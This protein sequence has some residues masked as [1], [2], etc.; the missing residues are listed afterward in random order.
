V[1]LSQQE[2]E[3]LRSRLNS[4]YV[5][6]LLAL[7]H[8]RCPIH[9]EY[10]ASMTRDGEMTFYCGCPFKA[11]SAGNKTGKGNL[12]VI[13]PSISNVSGRIRNSR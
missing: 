13:P 3:R 5:E 8:I 10:V 7:T 9:N 6:S 2:L 11:V 1:L 12:T 4:D